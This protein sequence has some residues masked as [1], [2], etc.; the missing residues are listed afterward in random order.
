MTKTTERN[1]V[2]GTPEIASISSC[3]KDAAMLSLKSA[4]PA[5]MIAASL[6]AV[7]RFST[8]KASATETDNNTTEE[9]QRQV[10][11]QHVPG[12]MAEQKT[13]PGFGSS[14]SVQ[15]SFPGC[16]AV[17]GQCSGLDTSGEKIPR[18]VSIRKLGV[19]LQRSGGSW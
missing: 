19:A 9:V 12:A 2:F 14:T 8:N 17:I 18:K 10:A 11:L 5:S 16:E 7:A 13:P 6:W 15:Y 1:M 4:G 3:W